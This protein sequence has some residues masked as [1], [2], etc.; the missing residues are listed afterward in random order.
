MFITPLP[1]LAE[2][3][4]LNGERPCRPRLSGQPEG[5]FGDVFRLDDR[6]IGG[7]RRLSPRNVLGEA[8]ETCSLKPTTGFYRDGCCSR[9]VARTTPTKQLAGPAV[10]WARY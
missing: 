4:R 3:P 10:G 7:G 8:L 6:G 1:R 2:R 5:A 9:A